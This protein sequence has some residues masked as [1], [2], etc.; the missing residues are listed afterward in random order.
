L[1]LGNN[2]GA[3]LNTAVNVTVYLSKI[4]GR[5]NSGNPLGA[6]PEGTIIDD[7]DKLI[8]QLQNQRVTL[9][10]GKSLTLSVPLNVPEELVTADG[11][12][13]RVVAK[14]EAV[15][16]ALDQLFSDDDQALGSR[17]HRWL[18]NFGT[19]KVGNDVRTH[20]H[21][22]YVE[23][24]GDRITLSM[25]GDGSGTVALDGTE[26]DP[27]RHRDRTGINPACHDGSR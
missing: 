20:A 25:H 16:A 10:S 2:G 11:K 1:R 4:D 5:D 8:G 15:G 6:D 17:Q 21:L 22:T 18:N 23:P 3:A 13:Y 26:R 7:T 27:H 19:F 24:D 12:S 9:E 14:T